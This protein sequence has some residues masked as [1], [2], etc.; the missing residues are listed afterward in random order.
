[1]DEAKCGAVGECT[2]ERLVIGH[3]TCCCPIRQIENVEGKGP[4][5]GEAVWA[6]REIR[7]KLTNRKHLHHP[8]PVARVGRKAVGGR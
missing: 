2:R 3:A 4:G 1:M 6:I 7:S 5:G 8:F